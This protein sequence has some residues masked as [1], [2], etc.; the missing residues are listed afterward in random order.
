VAEKLRPFGLACLATDPYV[1][2]FPDWVTPLPLEAL[3]ERADLVSLHCPL[4]DETRHLIGETRLRRMKPTA[5]LV[6]T[7]RGGVVDTTALV[8]ALREGWIAGAGLDVLDQ[9]PLPSGHPLAAFDN[10]LLTPHA[11][12]YSEGSIAELKRKVAQAVLDVLQGRR[13]ASVVN[14]GALGHPGASGSERG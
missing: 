7:A 13:P 1:A 6:N 5:I 9:E 14:P 2:V 10:V 12:F 3:L 11:A 4:T 8:R